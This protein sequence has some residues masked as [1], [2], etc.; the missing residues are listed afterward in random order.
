MSHWRAKEP[1]EAHRIPTE[2]AS[3]NKLSRSSAVN[4]AVVGRGGKSDTLLE[5]GKRCAAHILRPMVSRDHAAMLYDDEGLP[6]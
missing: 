1:D 2:A 5:I 6:R 4:D 3:H